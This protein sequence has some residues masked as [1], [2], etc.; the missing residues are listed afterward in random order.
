M[1]DYAKAG[2]I[3]KKDIVLHVGEVDFPPSMQDQLRKLG[4]TVELENG[5]LMLKSQFVVTE[6]DTPLTPEQSKLLALMKMPLISF[7]INL[8]CSWFNG[9][10]QEF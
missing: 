5:K 1:H 6:K 10:Y 9:E 2:A 3:P 7:K 8:L 4:L